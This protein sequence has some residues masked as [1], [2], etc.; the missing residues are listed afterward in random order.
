MDI[1]LYHTQSYLPYPITSNHI[2]SCHTFLPHLTLFSIVIRYMSSNSS[3]LATHHSQTTLQIELLP[4]GNNHYSQTTLTTSHI[5]FIKLLSLW[6]PR[7][8]L[9]HQTPLIVCPLS[10]L[11]NA[12]SLHLCLTHQTP[13]TRLFLQQMPTP[14]TCV[15]LIKLLSLEYGS[16]NAH[17]LDL[18]LTHAHSSNYFSV[19]NHMLN[20]S[21]CKPVCM[22]LNFSKI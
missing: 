1:L 13:L 19:D 3:H 7:L 20:S 14:F 10:H 8:C 12:H 9:T 4:L 17:P 5:C 22:L 16:S 11:S 21:N 2:L 15:R 18:F 6:S